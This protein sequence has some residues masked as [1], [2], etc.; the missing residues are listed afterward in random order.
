MFSSLFFALDVCAP[1][2]P[3]GELK[4]LTA[5]YDTMNER[6]TAQRDITLSEQKA[7]T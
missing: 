2:G 1:T 3:D 6:G 7:M 4:A 5:G